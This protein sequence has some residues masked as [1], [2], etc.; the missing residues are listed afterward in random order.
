[1][2]EERAAPPDRPAA[3]AGPKWLKPLVDYGPLLVF[4][5]AYL[6]TDILTATAAVVASSLIAVAL[7]WLVAKRIPLMSLLMAGARCCSAGRCCA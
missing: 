2:T 6:A 3:P 1:M 5:V 4:L 7:S